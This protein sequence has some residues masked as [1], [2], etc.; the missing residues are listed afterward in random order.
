MKTITKTLEET[1]KVAQDFLHTLIKNQQR[2]TVIGL[3]G[4]LG[5][6]KTAFV[7]CVASILGIENEI[8]SPTFVI[9]K[10]YKLNNRE[11]KHLIHIDAYRLESAQELSALGF[12]EI[13][14]N[15]DTLI[16]IEWPEKVVEIMPKN[17]FYI[18]FTFIDE[19]TREIEV[20]NVKSNT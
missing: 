9:E 3:R 13:I 14:A 12:A 6:G 8:T 10:I 20:Q 15:P 5:A 7:K 19:Q 2:A 18:N 4:N 1:K 11:F 17:T 16:M